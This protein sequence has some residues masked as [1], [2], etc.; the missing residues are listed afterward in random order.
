MK[1]SGATVVGRERRNSA[2]RVLGALALQ[3][4]N[5]RP[6]HSLAASTALRMCPCPVHMS[7]IVPRPD[8]PHRGGGTEACYAA[9]RLGAQPGYQ[10]KRGHRLESRWHQRPVY[11]PPYCK[12]STQSEYT[13]NGACPGSVDHHGGSCIPQSS[14]PPLGRV[15]TVLHWLSRTF[16]TLVSICNCPLGHTSF[17]RNAPVQ[18]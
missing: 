15:P 17:W 9:P 13:G 3:R 7:T 1:D 16:S 10:V 14:N 4:T 12:I 8:P 6:F 5:I 2:L 11:Q 18:R